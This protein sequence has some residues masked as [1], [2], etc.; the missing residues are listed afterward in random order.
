MISRE[1]LKIDPAKMEAILKWTIP[2]NVTEVR[3]FFAATQCLRKFIAS[4]S[5]V[6]AQLHAIIAS[7]NNF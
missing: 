5:T 4:F 1:E 3:S 2:T 7:D 6:V